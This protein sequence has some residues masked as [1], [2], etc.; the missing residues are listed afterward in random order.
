[1]PPTLMLWLQYRKL[2]QPFQRLFIFALLVSLILCFSKMRRWMKVHYINWEENLWT[3]RKLQK[4]IEVKKEGDR[5]LQRQRK[6][7]FWTTRAMYIKPLGS[8]P[9]SKLENNNESSEERKSFNDKIFKAL[10]QTT[11]L[12]EGLEEVLH[13]IWWLVP[14]TPTIY[15][16]VTNFEEE[17]EEPSP[18]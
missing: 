17:K 6:E 7:C 13:N 15:I 10:H 14:P 3:W 11:N 12:G 8:W 4:Q 9:P 16:V 1:M 5:K 2:M 18:T